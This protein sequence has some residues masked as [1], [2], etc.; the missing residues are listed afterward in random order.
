MRG[1]S[2]C[3]FFP[4]TTGS[5]GCGRRA[6]STHDIMG[7][8]ADN[9]ASVGFTFSVLTFTDTCPIFEKLQRT[10]A[11]LYRSPDQ[12]PPDADWKAV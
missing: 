4:S 9:V 7:I 1:P 3:Q 8:G 6:R 5:G 10:Q 2:T 11:D 12:Q